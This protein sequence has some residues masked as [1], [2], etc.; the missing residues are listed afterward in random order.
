MTF[1]GT[2]TTLVASTLLLLPCLFDNLSSI[3]NV[4]FIWQTLPPSYTP[5]VINFFTMTVSSTLEWVSCYGNLYQCAWLQVPL[6]HDKPNDEEAR[7]AIVKF[8]AK[9]IKK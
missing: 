9:K 3:L 2:C 4:N 5:D 6:N 7:L 8:P 1:H